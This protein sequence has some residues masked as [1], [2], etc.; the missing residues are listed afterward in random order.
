MIFYLKDLKNFSEKLLDH[1]QFQQNSRIQN[2]LTKISSILY[3]NNEQIEQEYKK[4][5]PF[6]AAS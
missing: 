2:Q 5:I 6:T 4:T 1:G 3:T